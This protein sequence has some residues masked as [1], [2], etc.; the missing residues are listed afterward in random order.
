MGGTVFLV[1]N[2]DDY[3]YGFEPQCVMPSYLG[4]DRLFSVCRACG[5]LHMSAIPGFLM[6]SGVSAAERIVITDS[7]FDPCLYGTLSGY[8]RPEDIF[9]YYMNPVN[10]KSRAYMD[11]FPGRAYSYDASDATRF[12]LKYKHL[13]YSDKVRIE[14][15]EPEYDALFLGMEKDRLPEIKEADAA[16]RVCGLNANIMI[17][18]CSDPGY[19][20][21]AY[22]PY[23]EYLSYMDKSRCI[24]EIGAPG[25]TACTLRFLESLFLKKKLITDNPR[26]TEDPYYDP[27]NVFVLGTDDISCLPDFAMIPYIDKHR[28][29]SD[30]TF[31][32]WIGD[33]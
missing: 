3:F 23:R 24:L 8:F 2:K 4:S 19:R 18:G 27:D 7:C 25:R 10:D 28:D 31:D 15:K 20:I 1:W 14:Q 22:M 21:P 13:P 17:P 12:G 5:R 26:I 16:L 6:S 29:L 32:R 11:L 30:I 9:L 33:W